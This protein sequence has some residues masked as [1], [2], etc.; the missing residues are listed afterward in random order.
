MFAT[1]VEAGK[2]ERALDLVER[3]H[4]EKSLNLA[5]TIADSHRKLVD[6]IEDVKD[7]KFAPADDYAEPEFT[8]QPYDDEDTSQRI[9]PDA[10][11]ARK[12]KRN[13]GDDPL[14]NSGPMRQVRQ[15]ANFA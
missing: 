15:K 3:L 7:R 5:M 9:S 10:D 6:L 12:G 2:L 8:D 14:D 11:Q 4:L 1:T 13:F